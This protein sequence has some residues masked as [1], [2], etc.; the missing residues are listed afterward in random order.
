MNKDEP[1]YDMAAIFEELGVLR[2]QN[3][4]DGYTI[5]RLT[6][7]VRPGNMGSAF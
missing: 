2:H 3:Q 6:A 4:E 7:A 5:A 1:K